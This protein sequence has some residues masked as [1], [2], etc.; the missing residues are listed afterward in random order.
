[1]RTIRL[2]LEDILPVRLINDAEKKAHRYETI[3]A[4]I[5]VVGLVEPLVV[6]PQKGQPGKYMLL[7]GHMRYYAMK[8]L[9]ISFADCI[10]ALDD[11]SFTYNARIS[12]LPAIQ[13]HKMIT[14]AVNSGASLERIAAALNISPRLVQAS[15]K[16][17]NGIHDEAV[18]LLKDKPISPQALRLLKKVTVERQIEIARLMIDAN[19]FHAGYGYRLR[20]RFNIDQMERAYQALTKNPDSRQ[21]VLQIWDATDDFPTAD[22]VPLAAD[23]PCN[24]VSILK[25]RGGALEWTQIMRSNDIFRGLP[26]NFVQFTSMQEILAGWLKINVGSYNHVSDSLHIY[27]RDLNGMES[28]PQLNLT[29]NLDSLGL[30]KHDFDLVLSELEHHGNCIIDDNIAAE[31]LL[32]TVRSCKLPIGLELG[33]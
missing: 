23:I 15:M 13:E 1:M 24:I 20:K 14:R 2:L 9:G 5:P 28:E 31:S 22:G 30:P 12:R 6:Y 17:L 3:L 7:N 33:E 26:Y 16:L 10:I 21:I 11:E 4:S 18:E 29:E 27:E 32:G 8:E 19:N 25:V